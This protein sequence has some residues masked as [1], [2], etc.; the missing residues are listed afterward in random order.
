VEEC[1]SA[2]AGTGSARPIAFAAGDGVA[3]HGDVLGSGPSTVVLDHEYPGSL[4]GWFPYAAEPAQ[5]GY[6]VLLFDERQQGDRLD[7]D[8]AAAVQEASAL[9]AQHVVAMGASLGGA[10][11]PTCTATARACRRSTPC[12]TAPHPGAAARHGQPRRSADRPGRGRR[13]GPPR[14]RRARRSD[15]GH[16]ARLEPPRGPER[17][18][19]DRAADAAFLGQAGA[20][21]ATGCS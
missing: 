3:L 1:G 4:C 7:L 20:P 19:E 6:R 9:G 13:P 14:A 16:A 5:S 11:T 17:Q 18:R 2:V 12:R 8:V 21:V 15:P 10:A